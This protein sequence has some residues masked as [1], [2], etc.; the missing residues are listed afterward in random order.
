MLN[1][2]TK[3]V[4]KLTPRDLE[5]F[6]VWAYTNSDR[7][8]ETVVRPI[9]RFPVKS[10]T[11]R[12][13]GTRVRLHNETEVWALIGNVDASNARLTQ[14][15]L[16]LSV[17]QSRRWF[18]LARYHDIDAARRGPKALAAFLKLTVARVF[19]ISYDLSRVC[20]GDPAA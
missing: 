10:L 12:V 9:K 2:D 11:C 6:P 8:D 4:D 3:R 20:T 1:R 14:H 16:T 18:T 19:P 5:E 7:P 17:F 13:V 15:F